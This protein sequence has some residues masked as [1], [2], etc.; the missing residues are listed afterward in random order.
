MPPIEEEELQRILNEALEHFLG[1]LWDKDQAAA[2]AQRYAHD[3]A[4]QHILAITAATEEEKA[5]HMRNIQHLLVTMRT[6]AAEQY[7]RRFGQQGK[8][9][10]IGAAKAIATILIAALLAA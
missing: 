1:G 4:E 8:Q 2:I 5:K 3:L 7:I 10:V 6:E 9:V